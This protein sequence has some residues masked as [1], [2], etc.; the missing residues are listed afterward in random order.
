[1]RNLAD[2][3]RNKLLVNG[4]YQILNIET[5]KFYIGSSSSKTFLY[6]RLI[7]HK[8][9]LI[10]N[11]HHSLYLQR[12]FNKYGIEKFYYQ[13]LEVCS[14]DNCIKREQYWIDLL[15]PDYNSCKVANSTL[16]TECSKEKAEKISKSNKVFWSKKENRE[17]MLISIKNRKIRTDYKRG[18]K[19]STYQLSEEG[20][21][22][23]I[24]RN[25]KKVLDKSTG[26]IY[27]SLKEASKKLN[28]NMT[29]LSSIL[30]NK[31]DIK[32]NHNKIILKNLT[33]L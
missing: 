16:G 12:S 14:P 26:K 30:N 3:P 17:R 28:I 19:N 8:R 4:V 5:N 13:I 23:I 20:K 9:D 33:W 7:H 21:N 2:I 27:N 32:T 10:N 11:K 18:Y 22:K 24:K 6:E 15:K 1:M 31:R 25:S 29:Y